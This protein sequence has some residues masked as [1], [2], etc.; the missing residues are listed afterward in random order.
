V[1]EGLV[2]TLKPLL[3]AIVDADA[4]TAEV[5][6]LETTLREHDGGPIAQVARGR[7]L[8]AR[9]RRDLA[10]GRVRELT[11]DEHTVLRY[12]VLRQLVRTPPR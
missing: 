9:E 6:K 5:A 8:G 1:I 7:L 3:D 11:R 2:Q 10:V 4:A 12:A